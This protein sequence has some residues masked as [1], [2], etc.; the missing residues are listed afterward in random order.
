MLKHKSPDL[1]TKNIRVNLLTAISVPI[2][3]TTTTGES[4][5]YPALGEYVPTGDQEASEEKKKRI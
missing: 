3:F 1:P 5:L 2:I 4:K